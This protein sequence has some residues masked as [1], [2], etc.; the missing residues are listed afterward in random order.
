MEGRGVGDVR[1]S[2]EAEQKRECQKELRWVKHNTAAEER[3]EK[4]EGQGL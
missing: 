2:G 4:R 3:Q 1:Q